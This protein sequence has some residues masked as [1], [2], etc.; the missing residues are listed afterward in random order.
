MGLRKV[1]FDKAGRAVTDVE[2]NAVRTESLHF[3]INGARDNG[4]RDS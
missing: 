3:V 1:T 2:I 4:K